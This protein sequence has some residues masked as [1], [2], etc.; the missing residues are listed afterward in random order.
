MSNAVAFLKRVDIENYGADLS[1]MAIAKIVADELGYDVLSKWCE[2]EKNQYLLYQACARAGIRPFTADSVEKYKAEMVRSTLA[3]LNGKTSHYLFGIAVVA[4]LCTAV[5]LGWR[6]FDLSFWYPLV[7]TI[8]TGFSVITLFAMWIHATA[9]EIV[10]DCSWSKSALERSKIKIPVDVLR[11]ALLLKKQLSPEIPLF[12]IDSL[13][14]EKRQRI[15]DYDPFL[16]VCLGDAE[17]YMAV[18]N[19]PKF[20]GD[21]E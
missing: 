2:K 11:K 7:A 10:T 3:A 17:A 20:N 12:R 19:E 5:F 8:V 14:V 6:E 18:W 4:V 9:Y 15:I 13:V 16:L 21:Y 1:G